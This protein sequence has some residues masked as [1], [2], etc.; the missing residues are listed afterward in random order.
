MANE[1]IKIDGKDYELGKTYTN[2]HGVKFKLKRDIIDWCV[3][4]EFIR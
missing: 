4:I 2:K 1:I 3:A